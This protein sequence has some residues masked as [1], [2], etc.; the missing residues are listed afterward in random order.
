MTLTIQQNHLVLA[1]AIGIGAILTTILIYHF[2]KKKDGKKLI[3]LE[4]ATKKYSLPLIEKEEVSHD[5]RRF[6]FGLP[7]EK[8]VLGLP[9]GQHIHLLATIDDDLII[10]S[11]TPVSSDDDHGY[12]DLVVKIYFKNVHP[13]FPD[14]G[15]MTQYLEN[16]KIGDTIDVRG[17]SGRLQYLGAGQFSIKKLRKDPPTITTAKRV[18]MIAGGTG[19]TPMLQLIRHITKDPSDKTEL[20]LLFANQTEKDIL[21]R[22]EL[23]QVAKDFPQQF[24]LWYTLDTPGDGW[25][26]SSGFVNDVML[27]EHFFEPSKDTLNVMCGPPPMINYAC[28]PNLEKLGHDKEMC[29]AY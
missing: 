4:D 2:S 17:P 5:T 7:S 24:K 6:R 26:Y 10:R 21:V 12:V 25:K 1:T 27:K 18:N 16:L 14:G 8:H 13:R 9:I 28:L 19:I 3:T 20:R 22:Q 29:F 15:K 23:E 11:Y